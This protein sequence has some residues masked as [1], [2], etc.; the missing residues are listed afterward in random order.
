MQ[1]SVQQREQ[2]AVIIMLQSV[3]I[4]RHKSIYMCAGV[5]FIVG[6]MQR[7]ETRP[8]T[9][10]QHEARPFV[11]TPAQAYIC[12]SFTHVHA[13]QNRKIRAVQGTPCWPY[14]AQGGQLGGPGARQGGILAC[15][16]AAIHPTRHGWVCA[17]Q[18]RIVLF[19]RVASFRPNRIGVRRIRRNY[20]FGNRIG[21]GWLTINLT[22]KLDQPVASGL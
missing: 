6:K 21:S 14:S 1:F 9:A 18:A 4:A 5:A 22:Q 11:H 16:V 10:L 15:V 20:G 8:N 17:R 3:Q 13:R 2:I 7:A 12:T 19:G